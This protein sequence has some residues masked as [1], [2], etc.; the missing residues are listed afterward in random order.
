MMTVIKNMIF[1]KGKEGDNSLAQKVSAN[2]Y[3]EEPLSL[4]APQLIGL[5]FFFPTA[6]NVASQFMTQIIS[7][8]SPLK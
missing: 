7:H 5:I 2:H 3:L 4:K 6:N 8:K 1:M